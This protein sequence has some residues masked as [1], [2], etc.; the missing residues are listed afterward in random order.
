MRKPCRMRCCKDSQR[1]HKWAEKDLLKLDIR[2]RGRCLLCHN[3]ADES[4]IEID[5]IKYATILG[6]RQML[7]KVY[8]TA[9]AEDRPI[10]K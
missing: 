2:I 7:V 6:Y 3:P 8:R 5:R 4:F 1:E 10:W 9:T